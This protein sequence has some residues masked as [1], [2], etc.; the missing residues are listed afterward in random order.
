M[1]QEVYST[2][3]AIVLVTKSFVI[4]QDV[5]DN[6]SRQFFFENFGTFQNLSE[7]AARALENIIALTKIIIQTP[8]EYSIFV[9]KCQAIINNVLV[10]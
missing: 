5:S 3:K 2:C 8:R 4:P 1:Y 7:R 6:M 10:L 9:Q